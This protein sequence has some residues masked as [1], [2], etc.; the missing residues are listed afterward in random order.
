MHTSHLLILWLPVLLDVWLFVLLHFFLSS[1]MCLCACV[2]PLVF[3]FIFFSSST[4]SG[5]WL[6]RAACPYTV[7]SNSSLSESSVYRL[8]PQT[9]HSPLTQAPARPLSPP[10]IAQAP[11]YPPLTHL[12]QT[13][14]PCRQHSTRHRHSLPSPKLPL[15]PFKPHNLTRSPE[16]PQI[17]HLQLNRSPPLPASSHCSHLLPL[18]PPPL[19]LH[20][21]LP[22]LFPHLPSPVLPSQ[23][24]PRYGA[25]IFLPTPS[26]LCPSAQW[27][28]CHPS[29]CT[30]FTPWCRRLLHSLTTRPNLFPS[31]RL[32]LTLP[33][34]A[35]PSPP[36]RAPRCTLP[37]TARPGP[38]PRRRPPALPSEAC[39][40]GRASTP[41]KTASLAHHASTAGNSK[42][43]TSQ[44]IFMVNT[45]LSCV[46]STFPKSYCIH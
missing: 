10:P 18:C 45:E 37:R 31:Y 17:Q 21:P 23:T 24:A 39:L 2:C 1:S 22:P 35:V 13:V 36:Q 16:P 34:E 25:P 4:C 12:L 9:C 30:T 44:E 20:P 29:G 27:C 7:F 8:S 46:F 19:L 38:P 11:V 40:G 5:S 41:S 14:S 42:V 28:P 33:L 43:L 6:Y 32:P 15:S 26:S 3:C